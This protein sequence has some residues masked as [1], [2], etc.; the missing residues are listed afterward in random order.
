MDNCEVE[1]AFALYEKL[2][3][4]VQEQL[5]S[6]PLMEDTMFNLLKQH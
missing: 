2:P 1:D 6:E 3:K 5:K 4:N